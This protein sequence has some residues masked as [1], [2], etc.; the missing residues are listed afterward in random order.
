MRLHPEDLRV[1]SQTDRKVSPLR[2]GEKVGPRGLRGLPREP[3]TKFSWEMGPGKA[4]P[5]EGEA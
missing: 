3:E 2:L 5:I 4:G 1:N